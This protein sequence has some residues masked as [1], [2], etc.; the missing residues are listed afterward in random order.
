ME[1]MTSCRLVL[2]YILDY[3]ISKNRV[4]ILCAF[5]SCWLKHQIFD[6][7]S[8]LMKEVIFASFL[9]DFQLPVAASAFLQL[10]DNRS[11]KQFQQ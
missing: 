6:L 2:V 8:E 5:V 4:F 3:Y 11:R 1:T 7:G 9:L 10:I